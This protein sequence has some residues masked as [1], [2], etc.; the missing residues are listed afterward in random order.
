MEE[1]IHKWISKLTI[2]GKYIEFR[3]IE[4][5]TSSH[6]IRNSYSEVVYYILLNYKNNDIDYYEAEKSVNHKFPQDLKKVMNENFFR[7]EDEDGNIYTGLFHV[8]LLNNSIQIEQIKNPESIYTK[9]EIH[10]IHNGFSIGKSHSYDD[11]V[12]FIAYNTSGDP[13]LGI[14]NHDDLFY[15]LEPYTLDALL[16]LLDKDLEEFLEKI[17]EGFEDDEIVF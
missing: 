11:S 14:H 12:I 6:H 13:M 7:I 15:H 16:A 1:L 4:N 5:K 3:I 2:F 9:E 10:L 8:G 17:I